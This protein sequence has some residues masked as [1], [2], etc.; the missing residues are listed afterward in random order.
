MT[1]LA[2]AQD[3]EELDLRCP[4]GHGADTGKLLARLQLAGPSSWVQPDN[5]IELACTDC[6]VRLRREGTSVARVLHRFNM[7]GE[8]VTTLVVGP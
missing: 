4:H 1:A 7:A 3:V 2:I 8:L 5:L 6:K